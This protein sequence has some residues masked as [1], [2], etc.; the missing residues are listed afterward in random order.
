MNN[1]NN[2]NWNEINWD[3]VLGA[4]QP[5]ILQ[6][7]GNTI[8]VG[9]QRISNLFGI[10]E[11]VDHVN[12]LANRVGDGGRALGRI[13]NN[14]HRIRLAFR[15]PNPIDGEYIEVEI[16][17]EPNPQAIIPDY[18]GVDDM[19]VEGINDQ[20]QLAAENPPS[21]EQRVDLIIQ[22]IEW[23]GDLSERLANFTTQARTHYV[24]TG[25]VAMAALQATGN[26]APPLIRGAARVAA[27]SVP[28]LCGAVKLVIFFL[29]LNAL[30]R[31][32]T[33]QRREIQV[34]AMVAQQQD[35]DEDYVP[36][37]EDID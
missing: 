27:Y 33:P 24:A 10:P 2:D 26:V 1:I 18:E 3:D 12:R 28:Q 30:T 7:I 22:G 17:E 23:A 29:M 16:G 14:I 25:A 21:I 31:E 11:R 9:F 35:E 34:V 13:A 6:G 15:A 4:P 37:V 5:T 8:R 19:P 32:L 36:Q 20:H